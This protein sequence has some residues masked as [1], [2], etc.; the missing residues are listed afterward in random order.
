M[1]KIT[2]ATDAHFHLQALRYVVAHANQNGC[3]VLLLG[4]DHLSRLWIDSGRIVASAESRYEEMR[5]VLKELKVMYF[6]WPGNYDGRIIEDVFGHSLIHDSSVMLGGMKLYAYGGGNAIEH[7]N[8]FSPEQCYN[9]WPSRNDEVFIKQIARDRK[10]IQRLDEGSICGA[11][12]SPEVIFNLFGN[13]LVYDRLMQEQPDIIGLHRPLFGLGDR[14]IQKIA[15]N[16][17]WAPPKAY[18]IKSKKKAGV[19]FTGHCHDNPITTLLDETVIH[20]PGALCD[21]GRSLADIVG[22]VGSF[23]SENGV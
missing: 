3:K 7:V 13:P 17:G 20:S 15:I 19:V 12:I 23:S 11:V 22:G 14:I 5:D 8:A 21:S 2:Y 16:I 10:L 4:G 18:V 6:L 1:Y 9:W